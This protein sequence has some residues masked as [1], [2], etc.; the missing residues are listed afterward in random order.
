MTMSGIVKSILE[1]LFSPGPPQAYRERSC[2]GRAWR[3]QFPE[4]TK[5]EIR[6]FLSCFA[7]G[8]A[9]HE[10]EKLKFHP[11]DALYAIYRAHYP[12]LGWGDALELET[13][14][15]LLEKRYGFSLGANW[16]ESLT[17]GQVFR[18]TLSGMTP[19]NALERP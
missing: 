10:R 6:A 4:A 11:N 16:S 5:H 19:N 9:Y 18:A 3:G 14:H 12:S 2:Q 1:A 7:E 15:A 13:F 8:F 17:L